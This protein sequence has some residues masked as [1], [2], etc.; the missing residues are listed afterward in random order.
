H[1]RRHHGRLRCRRT[2]RRLHARAPRAARS[3]RRPLLPDRR[4]PVPARR[5]VP[6]VP[7]L[8]RHRSDRRPPRRHVRRRVAARGPRRRRRDRARRGED[9]DARADRHPLHPAVRRRRV[10]D[11]R[12]AGRRRSPRRARAI[13]VR[14]AARR[15]P[16]RIRTRCLH[17][18]AG[19]RRRRRVRHRLRLP[20]AAR[21]DRVAAAARPRVSRRTSSGTCGPARHGEPTMTPAPLDTTYLGLH[22]AHP[23]M[24]G[25]S[26]LADDLDMVRRL[27]DGG[28]SAIVLRSLFE[29]QITLAESGRI[30]EMDPHESQF[31][32]A[33]AAFPRPDRYAFAPDEYLEHIR[34]VKQAVRVPVIASL[35]GMTAHSWLTFATAIEAAGADALELN[36]Y[37]VVTDISQ[38]S[39]EIETEIRNVLV[40]L[41]RAVTLPVALKLL[42]YFTAF[43]HVAHQLDEAGA[44]GLILFNRFYEPD[45]DTAAIA[46]RA[47]IE[48]S[49]HGELPLR[50][51]WAAILH[52]R[53]HC[54][55]A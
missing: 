6:R 33:L 45:I 30:H 31:A 13:R 20:A 24:I 53:L 11:R 16:R 44:D 2:P 51:R 38:S 5:R 48:L 34:R 14:A 19:H 36:L 52:S 39:L 17:R 23:F 9:L 10:R 8:D 42:P 27:E 54:S 3:R 29:E 22:L 49:D 25:A 21:A 1:R 15:R 26:P 7:A 4:E 50:L 43:G 28:S 35:N 55:I 46:S 47:K 37:K 40:D 32:P 18:R 12:T 41:K